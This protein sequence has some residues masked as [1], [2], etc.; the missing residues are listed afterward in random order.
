MDIDQARTFLAVMEHGSFIAASEQLHVT[1]TAVSARI[2]RLETQLD[3]RLFVRDQSG[4]RPT[5]AGE[6][7]VR[8]AAALVST[9]EDARQHIAVPHGRSQAARIGGEPCVWSPLL[10]DWLV[11]MQ[12]HCPDVATRVDVETPER[13]LDRLRDG[14]LDLAVLYGLPQVSHLVV[15]L[16]ADEALVMVTTEPD[17][18]WSPDRYIHV[19]WGSAFTASSRAAFPE[20]GTPAVSISL[21]PLA[22]QYLEV[23]GGC[24]YFRSSVV[25]RLLEA[26]SLTRVRTAPEFSHSIYAV[27]PARHSGVIERIRHGLKAC[28]AGRQDP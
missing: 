10:V 22:L 5:A 23:A 25:R 21:G 14:T 2:Q 16:L 17:G 11:W 20:V 15:E 18:R 13:L 6:R 12:D 7:F 9:W 4:A 24:G 19:D 26:G 1:Q 8:Y 27:Y 3:T 28:I